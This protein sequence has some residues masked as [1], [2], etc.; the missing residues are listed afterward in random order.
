MSV[1]DP[2]QKENGLQGGGGGVLLNCVWCL[3]ISV[4]LCGVYWKRDMIEAIQA[5]D[6]WHLRPFLTVFFPHDGLTV[7]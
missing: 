3:G 4:A 7:L 2:T 5:T 6:V 1:F